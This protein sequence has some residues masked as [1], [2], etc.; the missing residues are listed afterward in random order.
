MTTKRYC[1]LVLWGIP[2][3]NSIKGTTRKQEYQVYRFS[4]AFTSAFCI[5]SYAWPRTRLMLY[6]FQTR[7]DM[8]HTLYAHPV[9]SGSIC[10]IV[11]ISC[12]FLGNLRLQNLQE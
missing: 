3:Q 9:S 10:D 12:I 8:L 1:K 7:Y 11:S 5:T 6:Y 4:E 2:V